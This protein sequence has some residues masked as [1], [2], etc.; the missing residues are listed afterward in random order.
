M[1]LD[2]DR[3]SE[4]LGK[5]PNPL[6]AMISDCVLFL[7][8]HRY[9]SQHGGLDAHNAHTYAFLHPISILLPFFPSHVRCHNLAMPQILP[10]L[11]IEWVIHFKAYFPS[12][13]DQ[14]PPH[15]CIGLLMQLS[16]RFSLYG[17]V[18]NRSLRRIHTLLMEALDVAISNNS[19]QDSG[20]PFCRIALE[21][22]Q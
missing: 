10:R 12:I 16:G 22:N 13:H 5:L 7:S 18:D 3:R 9:A 6:N 8:D 19:H 15:V 4:C 11:Q 20:C 21:I 1:L 17:S 2:L 14:Q